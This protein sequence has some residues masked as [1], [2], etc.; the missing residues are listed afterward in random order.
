M[1][2]LVPTSKGDLSFNL[3]PG[4]VQTLHSLTE[5]CAS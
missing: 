1:K 3:E 4:Q 5:A 2:I